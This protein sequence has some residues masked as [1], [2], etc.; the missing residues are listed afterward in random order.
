[1]CLALSLKKRSTLRESSAE[2]LTLT[3]ACTVLPMPAP[4][5]GT[6]AAC[7]RRDD[8]FALMD[9]GQAA[10][11]HIVGADD[12]ISR[13][14]SSP[15]ASAT[16]ARAGRGADRRRRRTGLRRN[17]GGTLPPRPC[18]PRR[19]SISARRRWPKKCWRSRPLCSAAARA[20]A[21]VVVAVV[22]AISAASHLTTVCLG[23]L[24]EFD[25]QILEHLDRSP[26]ATC[27]V[28]SSETAQLRIECAGDV[29]KITRSRAPVVRRST[30]RRA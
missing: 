20:A 9:H 26:F 30:A 27:V 29:R 5:I 25:G 6:A 10:A 28:P 21:P 12:R 23:H 15:R 4:V 16:T 24:D 3:G 22:L 13:R 19:R 11:Q 2:M 1:M 8:R 18:R 14:R 7:Y 17:R